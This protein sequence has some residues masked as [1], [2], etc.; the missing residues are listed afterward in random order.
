MFGWKVCKC[1]TLIRIGLYAVVL[2]LGK[3]ESFMSVLL[4]ENATVGTR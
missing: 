3:G 4:N 1:L 2:A